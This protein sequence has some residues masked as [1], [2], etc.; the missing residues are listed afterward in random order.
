M[1]SEKGVFQETLDMSKE[2]SSKPK[3]ILLVSLNFQA[4]GA[5]RQIINIA[6]GL[7]KKGYETSVFVLHNKGV[8]RNSL[9]E[10]VKILFP[11]PVPIIRKFWLLQIV[12]GTVGLFMTVVAK[13]PDI[14]YSRHWTKMPLAAIGR[15]LGIKTVSAEVNNLEE[16]ILPKK[17]PLFLYLRKLGVRWSDRVL[18]NSKS[19]ALETRDL[20]GL[21]CDIKVIYNGIDVEYIRKRSEEEKTHKWFGTNTPLIIATGRFTPQKGFSHLL[22]SLEIVNR[23]KTAHLI[24]IGEGRERKNLFKLRK[25]LSITDRVNFMEPVPNPFPYIKKADIFVCSSM[26]EGLSNVI[27]EAMALGKPVISTDHKHGANEIIENNRNGIL[28]PPANP[29][30]LAEAILKTLEDGELRKNLGTEAKK[31]AEDFSM[32]TMISEYEELFS[33]M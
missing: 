8:L 29:Q 15:I 27:L 6:N 23:S 5:Q 18:A 26:Y 32:D 3:K 30:S 4:G 16:T 2:A 12:Y 7:H 22:K 20:F 1:C 28:V 11:P 25:E 9:N 31:R 19:L 21:D 33:Q 14:L 24:I 17:R 10:N 13:K